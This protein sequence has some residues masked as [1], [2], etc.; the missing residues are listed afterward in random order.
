MV[1]LRSIARIALLVTLALVPPRAIA[2]GRARPPGAALVPHSDCASLLGARVTDTRVTEAVAV[3]NPEHGPVTVPHCRVAGIIDTEIRFIALLPDD[4]NGKFFA[5]GGGG[6]VGQVQNQAESSVNAGYASIGTDTGHQ[7]RGTEASWALGHPERVENFGHRAVH[8]TAE[9][10]KALVAAYYGAAP[11]RSYFFGCSNGGRQALMEA[12]RYPEDFDGIVACAPALDMTNIAAEFVAHSQIAFPDPHQLDEPILTE[13]NLKLL[14]TRVLAACDALDGVADGVLD[15]PRQCRFQVADLPLCPAD[16]EAPDCMTR[17]Q[18][19]T[20]ARLYAPT[21]SL[22][23]V[24]YPGQ[25]FGGEGEPG[26]WQSWITGIDPQRQPGDP[27]SLQFAFATE[28]FKYLVFG[29]PDWDYSRYDL[30][31]WRR[32]T[33]ALASIV[34]ADN[35]DLSAFA[36]GHRKLILAH[37]WADPALNPL[38]TIAYYERVQARDPTLREYARLFMMPGVLHC[39]GGRGP[40]QVDWFRAIADW[41]ERGVGPERLIAR[42]IDRNGRVLNTR[43]LCPYPARAVYDGRGATTDAATFTCRTQ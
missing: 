31:N 39:G 35:P 17:R 2:T 21:K 14:E 42:K 32:D 23:A 24:V 43:P 26:G 3:S 19:D 10:G 5:G 12:Q 37:G 27:P 18:R 38:S 13:D 22:G 25:P 16:R 15:D 34:N 30:A 40:D 7:G 6:F 8:R 28:G 4:W 11:S 9:V 33:A 41:V 20:A 36:R 29:R 1:P